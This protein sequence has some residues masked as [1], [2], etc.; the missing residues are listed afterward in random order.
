MTICCY[1]I[2]SINVNSCFVSLL[3]V[4]SSVPVGICQ[5]NVFHRSEDVFWKTT[6][7]MIK[8]MSAS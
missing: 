4:C 8:K 5:E 2:V 6:H 3:N 1:A 7:K